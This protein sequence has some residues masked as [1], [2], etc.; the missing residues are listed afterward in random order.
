[1]SSRKSETINT[2]LSM[3]NLK[4]LIFA[5][6]EVSRELFSFNKFQTSNLRN[7]GKHGLLFIIENKSITCS[8]PFAP[9][10]QGSKDY[11]LKESI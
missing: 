10:V 11:L 3:V 8:A 5:I 1:M 2:I 6:T 9:V 7:N 4:H